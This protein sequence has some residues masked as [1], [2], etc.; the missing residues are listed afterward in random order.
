[1]RKAAQPKANK[2]ATMAEVKQH[3]TDRLSMQG[4]TP[5]QEAKAQYSHIVAAICLWLFLVGVGIA[6]IVQHGWWR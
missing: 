4:R 5:V 1:M 3:Q 2:K 6:Y